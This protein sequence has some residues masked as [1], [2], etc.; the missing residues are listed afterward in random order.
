MGGMYD[1]VKWWQWIYML[2]YMIVVAFIEFV[3]M[4]LRR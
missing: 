2:P 1:D 4:N 3:R